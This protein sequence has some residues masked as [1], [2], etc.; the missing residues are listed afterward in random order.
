V[1][2]PRAASDILAPAMF[3]K[4][5]ALTL[6]MVAMAW[7]RTARAADPAGPTDSRSSEDKRPT[8]ALAACASGDVAKGIA[9]LGELYAE[10]LNPAYVFNQARC[11]Q[12]NDK[13][14]QARASFSEYL[15]LGANEPP[16]DIQ[17]AQAFIKEIDAALERQRASAPA[18][19]VSATP[20]Q[21]SADARAH[22]LR[23]TSIVLAGVGVAAVATGAFMSLKV[24]QANDDINQQFAGKD[25][26]TDGAA[27]QRQIA[28]GERYETWQWVSYGVGVAA[29]AGAVTTFVLAGGLHGGPADH[30][31]V[32][33]TPAL[34]PDGAGGVVRVR[35]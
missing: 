1:H 16:E 32:D 27:L 18:P 20:A 6:L 4:K 14:E 23:I 8:T 7:G 15:R 34:S 9:I 30:A 22:T 12:K 31:L 29:L 25:Y 33:V 24:K 11:Y 3:F 5:V 2:R 28:D 35:F 19:I 13:L 17:R 10:T 21:P 26:V